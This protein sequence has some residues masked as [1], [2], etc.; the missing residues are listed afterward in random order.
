MPQS[1]PVKP[2]RALQIS[3]TLSVGKASLLMAAMIGLS[4]LTGF[5]RMMLVSHLY[6]TGPQAAAFEAAFN[7]PDTIATLIAGGALATGFV[8]V[9]TEYLARGEHDKAQRTFRAMW[10]LLGCVFGIITIF[11]FGLTWTPLAVYLAPD[12]LSPEYVQLYLHLLR[13]LLV[14]QLFFVIGG[15]FTGTLN[16]LRLFVYPA[17]QPVVFNL[18]IIVLGIILPYGFGMDISAQAWGALVGAIIGS[19]LIQAPA[20]RRSGLSLRPLW[21]LRDEG[22]W[23]VLRSLLPIV[24]GLASGQIIA[25]NLARFFAFALPEAALPAIGYANRLMQVPLDLLASGPAI[26]LFPTLALLC[27][28]GELAQMRTQLSEVLRRTLALTML[29]TALLAALRFPVLELL[30]QH[31]KFDKAATISTAPVLL[32]YSFCIVGLGAQQLL[33]RG[34]YATGETR[35]P[36]VA[37]VLAIITFAI[38]GFL[39]LRF[40]PGAMF[41]ALAAAVA[42]TLLSIVMGVWLAKKLGG[43]DEGATLGVLWKSALA[44]LLCYFVAFFAQRW[45]GI[46]LSGFDTNHTREI[47]KLAAR[48]VVVCGGAVA[49]TVSFLLVAG[50]LGVQEL[51]PLSK[52]SDKIFKRDSSRFFKSGKV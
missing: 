41:L 40:A 30:L 35:P 51:G 52:I 36:I 8:P 21:D 20:V 19:L 33:A 34:F 38:L 46:A 31:G 7:I 24:F 10:T 14:A 17:L 1:T 26:A 27:A 42:V 4:R 9:F 28:Q 39:S 12:K 16:A 2:A 29:A 5:G 37:G 6:G 47:F 48:G 3:N 13:I 25:L 49:G 22:V 23:R 11:L 15:L 50:V 43:W 44:A 18:G 32:A 45:L